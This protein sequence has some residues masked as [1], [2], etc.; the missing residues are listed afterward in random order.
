MIYYTS[1]A[2][3]L[4]TLN[5]SL[6]LMRRQMVKTKKKERKKEEEKNMERKRGKRKTEKHERE[7]HNTK[8]KEKRYFFRRTCSQRQG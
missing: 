3:K 2:S 7:K 6:C 8:E 4:L 5:T 1:K